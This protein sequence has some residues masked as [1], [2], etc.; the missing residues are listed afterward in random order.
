MQEH[1]NT[2]GFYIL[3]N[4]T[5]PQEWSDCFECPKV[6][7][8]RI[9]DQLE[10]C[11]HE[12]NLLTGWKS[13][14]SKFRASASCELTSSNATDAGALHRDIMN[15]GTT[16]P[17]IYTLVLYLDAAKLELVPCSHRTPHMTF[18]Q[19]LLC[20]P[21]VQNLNAG[22]AVLFHAS[23]L[24]AGVFT[25]EKK[26]RRVIQ[27]FDIFR[28]SRE[29]EA[30]NSRVLHIWCPDEAENRARGE[31]LSKHMS[32]N[33]LR[34]I[35]SDLYKFRSGGG[36]ANPMLTLPPGFTIVSGESYR[37]R[38]PPHELNT[39]SDANVYVVYP[40]MRI[41]DASVA[42]IQTLRYELYHIRWLPLSLLQLLSFVLIV[43]LSFRLLL[44]W[45]R[46]I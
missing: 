5:R 41:N 9:V 16:M 37:K 2:S 3:R 35:V 10:R 20:K 18:L 8:G 36:Y 22:D 38:L 4:F 23:L 39:F 33:L 26:E 42:D 31:M 28:N 30:W 24:H 40:G 11:R 7:H 25:Q 13:H 6:H 17:P 29:Y 32:T 15:Y 19:N 12:L 27:C 45:S 44:N 1:L 21:I 43:I 14:I 34:S 46:V